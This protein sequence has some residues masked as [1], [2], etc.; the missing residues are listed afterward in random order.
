MAPNAVKSIVLAVALFGSLQVAPAAAVVGGQIVPRESLPWLAEIGR[1]GCNGILVAPDRVLTAGHCIRGWT[2][3]K[4]NPIRVAGTTRRGIRFSMPPGWERF[5]GH[6]PFEDVAVIQFD[7][8]VPGVPR[9]SIGGPLPDRVRVAGTGLYEPFV[10]GRD[11]AYDGQLRIAELRPISDAECARAY[12][13][14]TG[15]ELERFHAVEMFCA[16]DVDGIAPLSSPCSGDDGG[17]LYS[18]P[19]S[20]PL[21]H[22]IFTWS[23]SLCGADHLP[24]V[25]AS[26]NRLREFITAHSPT[27]APVAGQRPVI[28]GR[29]RPGR[30]LRCFVPSWIIP[31]TN[32]RVLW[33]RVRPRSIL[34]DLSIAEGKTYVVQRG[35]AG[36][37]IDCTIKASNAGGLISVNNALQVHVPQR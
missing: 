34:I 28:A 7:A 2:Y 11:E 6:N 30:R 3:S 8:P 36:S 4:V 24:S 16:T 33:H 32:V 14:R 20:A 9:V 25:Y 31:P 37:D 23:G 29:P 26:V 18:G 35:D 22:G 17:P 13:R 12:R 27:W 10:S 15:S 19:E 5:N 1:G 21:L